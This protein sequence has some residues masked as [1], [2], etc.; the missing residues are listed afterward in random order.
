MPLPVKK[1]SRDEVL[2]CVAPFSK[3]KPV[4]NGLPDME[5]EECNRTFYSVI[6]FK[7]PKGDNAFSPFGDAVVPHINHLQP[8]FGMSYVSAKP[9]KGVLMHNHDTNETFV[10]MKGKWKME[11]EGDKGNEH[12]VLGPYDTVSF[13]V[14]IQRRFECVEA[15]QGEAEGL[16]LAVI[17]GNAPI[18]E[19][20]PEAKERIER[21]GLSLEKA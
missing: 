2:K 21:A 20:S 3:L 18:A 1:P 6:G 14:A 11:W 8:G 17:G 7:Q 15:P 19:F 9:G 4:T 12:V 10:V 5:L 13:P 16:M